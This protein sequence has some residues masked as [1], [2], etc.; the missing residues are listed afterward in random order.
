MATSLKGRGGRKVDEKEEGVAGKE[1]LGG[2]GAKKTVI[3]LGPIY[4]SW[5]IAAPVFSQKPSIS[6]L[7]IGEEI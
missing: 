7:C 5:V 2:T 1:G 4:R 3:L 6:D